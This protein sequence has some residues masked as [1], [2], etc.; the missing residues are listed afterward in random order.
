MASQSIIGKVDRQ[1]KGQAI[2]LG[3]NGDPDQAGAR[4]LHHYSEEQTIDHLSV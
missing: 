2:Y 4:L 1:G 3:Q